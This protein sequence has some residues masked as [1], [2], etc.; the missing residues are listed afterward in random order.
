MASKIA[1]VTGGGRGLGRDMALSLAK[2]GMD[3]VVTYHTKKEETDKVVAE[4][5][6]LGQRAFALHLDVGNVSSLDGFITQLTSALKTNWNADKFDYLVNNGGHGGTVPMAQ[7]TEEDFDRFVN[8]HF[9][10]VYF[11]TQKALPLINDHGGVIFISSGSTRFFVPGYS[12]YASVKGAL[13]VLTKYVAKEYGS[14]GIRANIVAPGAIETDFNS[15]ALRSNPERKKMIA[16]QSPLN[17]VGQADDIGSVVAFLCS[18]DAK[19]IDG[20]RIE[21]SG[22]IN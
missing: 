2:K 15:A 21:V 11:L 22:G 17:R 6:Q 18:D 13:E 20:Q 12:V 3:V 19:W 7:V 1:L 5:S 9:K 16:A 14:R 10:G 8:V 4:I